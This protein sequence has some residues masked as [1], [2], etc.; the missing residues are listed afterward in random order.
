MI[1]DKNGPGLRAA[2]LG[3]GVAAAL[4]LGGC[5]NQLATT[6]SAPAFAV[7]SIALDRESDLQFAREALPASLKTLETFLVNSPAQE[8][9]LFLLAKGFN[10]YAF[11]VLE[12]DLERARFDGDDDQVNELTRRSVLHYLRAR[13]YGFRSLDFPELEG[14]ALGGDLGAVRQHAADLNADDAPDLFWTLQA[15][16][17][18]VNLAQD[19]PD[20]VGALPVIEVLLER[21]VEL[22]PGYAEGMPLAVWGT[23]WASR[24]AMFGGNPEKAKEIFER[25]MAAHGSKN[26]LIPYLY[27]RFYAP[28]VQDHKLFNQLMAQVLEA[29]VTKHPD[30][31]LNNEVARDRARFW[32]EHADELFFE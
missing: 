18:A 24:P 26:L 19:D 23:Y 8:D 7:G 27:A 13:E 17:A 21:L 20:M 14:A 5:L 10:S 16:A 15:W 31:R 6:S 32:V 9:L 11:A 30:L 25:A 28:Q 2:G 12:R 29:D 3:L 22:D 1:F 4:T